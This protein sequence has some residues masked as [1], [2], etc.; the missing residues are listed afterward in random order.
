M[1]FGVNDK[2]FTHDLGVIFE[3]L[4]NKKKFSFSKYAD[5]EFEILVD[6]KIT[7]CDNWTYNPETD[8]QYRDELLH[9]F[10]YNEEGYY[11]G[12]SCPCCVGNANTNWMRNT[13]GVDDKNLTWANIFVNGNYNFFKDNFIP[14]FA[15]H[16]IILVANENANVENLPF[17][18][19]E[20][21]KVTGTAWKDNFD[22]VESLPNKEYKD[23]LFLFCAGPLGNMLAARMWEHN[24]NNTYIDIG[25][26]LNTWLVGA[27]RGYLRGAATLN[28]ICIW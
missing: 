18:V 23:K 9:S 11:V 22:L 27:N 25:S 3:N 5:G 14:E 13:V 20:H 28:K 12:I 1:E 8:Q 16:D 26:T 7:N 6:R 15:N 19:E 10:K 4:K 24:K 2:S 17:K 21:I